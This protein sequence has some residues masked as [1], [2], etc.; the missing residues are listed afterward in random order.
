M[1]ARMMVAEQRGIR[2][3][4]NEIGT[5]RDGGGWMISQ[6]LHRRF[7]IVI[8][9][10]VVVFALAFELVLAQTKSGPQV[11]QK[12]FDVVWK[13][14]NE[15]SFD[16]NFGG[17][18]WSA[19]RERYAPQVGGVK[20]DRELIDLLGRMLKEMPVSHLNLL[21]WDTLDASLGRSVVNRGLALRDLDGQV[22]VTRVVHGS[23]A[24]KA[25]VR[26]G[27]VVA[28]INDVP[29]TA[30]RTAEATLAG[31]M[32]PYRLALV[33]EADAMRNVVVEHQLP[34][35]DRL[36]VASIGSAKRY[37]LLESS[38]LVDGI[39]YIHFTN[40]IGA[41]QKRVLAAVEGLKDTRGLII[42]L[43]GNSGGETE[44]GMALASMLVEKE[45]Q[46][47][48]MRTRDG[49][50]YYDKAKPRKDGYR[51][52]VVILLDEESA[53]ESEDMTAGLQ[54]AG[55]AIVIGRQSRG[56]NMDATYQELP[57]PSV[58]LLY[59]TGYPRTPKGQII[60]GRG[61]IPDIEVHLTRS[62]LVRGRD[63]QLEAA[64]DHLRSKK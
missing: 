53:S 52:A 12:T 41:V 55:R 43:R 6:M 24:D 48:I 37:V 14:V 56:V 3:R 22:V 10:A 49:D 26:P 32:K 54:E 23:S 45:T 16:P 36:T 2:G 61:V 29:V 64:L 21:E 46:L 4:V 30:A 40:F 35:S 9:N 51:G 17:V 5:S 50:D 44:V 11:W 18:N 57:L 1:E 39:G 33:D 19:V 20:S 8:V 34:P 58:G 13:T 42:D 28:A 63:A 25:G 15:K 38:R 7:A 62:E 31:D 27:F 47:A 60:E 59:P